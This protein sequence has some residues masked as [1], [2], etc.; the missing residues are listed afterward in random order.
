MHYHKGF[1]LIEVLIV[2]VILMTMVSFVSPLGIRQIE[3]A[4]AHQD[5]LTVKR[6]I[7]NV[8]NFSYS[9]GRVTELTFSKNRV[10]IHKG[11]TEKV[12][13]LKHLN[14]S[15]EQHLTFNNNG[16]PDTRVLEY[17][18]NNNTLSLELFD[19]LFPSEFGYIHEP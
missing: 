19:L 9:S 10:T 12:V 8:S 17:S 14:F 16:Y 5:L 15:Q 1:T 2:I 18:N 11:N 13:E 3:R 4:Q 7:V 6:L